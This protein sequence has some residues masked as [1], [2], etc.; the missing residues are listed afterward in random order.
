[1]KRIRPE[2]SFSLYASCT[3]DYDGRARSTLEKG[4]YLIIHKS[5]G[6]LLIHGG[7]LCTPRNYQPPGAI[8]KTDKNRII[9]FRKNEIIV[10]TISKILA[11]DEFKDWS[12]Q[13]I[14]ITKTEKELRDK[15]VSQID[16]Y[17][18]TKVKEVHVEFPTPVGNIDILAIDENNIYHVIEVKRGKA[19]LAACSQLDRYSTYFINI[20][21]DV[22][23]YIASPEV[24]SNA[25]N[26]MRTLRQSWIKAVHSI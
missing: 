11:Y 8:L 5:D 3:V 25:T 23:D 24:S 9:S 15:I 16:K 2:Q 14:D 7:T 17:L 6:T 20:M 4:N 13:R 21:K 10:I 12:K 18:K 19:S 1:V 22:K 26:H